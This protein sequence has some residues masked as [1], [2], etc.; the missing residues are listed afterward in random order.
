MRQ[1]QLRCVD[2]FNLVDQSGDGV[3]DRDELAEALA[4][5]GLKMNA[6]EIDTLFQ[7]L[8]TSGDGTIESLELEAAIRA[9]R[10]FNWEKSMIEEWPAQREKLGKLRAMNAR[11]AASRPDTAPA[12]AP[13]PSCSATMTPMDFRV[14]PALSK[15]VMS[16]RIEDGEE[17]RLTSN[18]SLPLIGQQLMGMQVANSG[19]ATSASSAS[20]WAPAASTMSVYEMQS[21][22]AIER[23]TDRGRNKA[24]AD[25]ERVMRR[26]L[27]IRAALKRRQGERVEMERTVRTWG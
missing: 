13:T 19:V 7:F 12:V 11:V 26:R 5:V 24:N 27:A 6:D 8:D 21:T 9:Y 25:R 16:G 22:A 20:N 4:M 15:L 14:S 2:L 3:I 18:T 17:D 23:S 1:M 10:R